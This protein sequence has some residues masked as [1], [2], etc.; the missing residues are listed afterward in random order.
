M[1]V[2]DV[3][4]LGSTAMLLLAVVDVCLVRVQE[5]EKI[6]R[7]LLTF[8]LDLCWEFQAQLLDISMVTKYLLRAAEKIP[9]VSSFFIT[10]LSTGT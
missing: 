9:S 4:S 3:N 1:Q 2:K 5:T 7:K 8:L 10:I 6:L